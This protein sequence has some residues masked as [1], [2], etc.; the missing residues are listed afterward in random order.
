MDS[1]DI[2][3]NTYTYQVWHGTKNR[4]H[5]SSDG[6]N[7]LCGILF[8]H[9]YQWTLAPSATLAEFVKDVHPRCKYCL[10]Q[11][12][13]ILAIDDLA[14]TFSGKEQTNG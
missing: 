14:Q 13:L 7:T 5:L 2:D 6:T 11:A 4:A 1:D 10:N 8:R 12:K 9:N 3:L